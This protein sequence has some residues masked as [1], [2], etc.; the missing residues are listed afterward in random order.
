MTFQGKDIPHLYMALSLESRK[1]KT[2]NPERWEASKEYRS[3]RLDLRGE[4]SAPWAQLSAQLWTS[5]ALRNCWVSAHGYIFNWFR[6]Y[7]FLN[8]REKPKANALNTL[9]GKIPIKWE[10]SQGT[11][12]ACTHLPA[13]ELTA[14]HFPASLTA[15]PPIF[16]GFPVNVF[17][18][19]TLSM[20]LRQK[21]SLQRSDNA[22]RF[23]LCRFQ[24][25]DHQLSYLLTQLDEVAERRAEMLV[26]PCYERSTR[27]KETEEKAEIDLIH[28][29]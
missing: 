2:T 29:V 11:R 22:G 23:L 26:L 19:K 9:Q 17:W 24:G 8:S 10:Q 3:W 4:I 21:F 1:K 7:R 6:S 5:R 12:K 20:S 28:S 25:F 13:P 27:E 14:S 15:A 18:I 16:W